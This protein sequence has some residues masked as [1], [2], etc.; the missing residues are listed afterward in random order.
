MWWSVLSGQGALA[1][2]FLALSAMPS[3]GTETPISG[4]AKTCEAVSGPI[5]WVVLPSSMKVLPTVP[6]AWPMN[7]LRRPDCAVELVDR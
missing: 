3:S 5:A 7:G 6:V 4:M 2:G 1:H